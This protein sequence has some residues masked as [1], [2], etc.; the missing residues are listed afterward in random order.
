MLGDL[1]ARDLTLKSPFSR[2]PAQAR[3]GLTGA[4]GVEG[5]GIA[6]SF[7]MY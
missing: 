5:S 3:R 4:I 6:H 1:D 7:V 2:C